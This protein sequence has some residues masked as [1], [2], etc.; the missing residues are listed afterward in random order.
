[1]LT[2]FKSIIKDKVVETVIIAWL[3]C[4]VLASIG[5]LFVSNLLAV[6]NS[7]VTPIVVVLLATRMLWTV[8]KTAE[9]EW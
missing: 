1:M 2:F 9:Y 5:T 3:V 6:F 4:F 8:W 7:A